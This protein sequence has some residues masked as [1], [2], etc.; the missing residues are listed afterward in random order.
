PGFPV[1]DLSKLKSV[2][3]NSILSN[4]KIY[5]TL[6]HGPS[7]QVLGKLND[8]TKL[9]ATSTIIRPNKTMFEDEIDLEINPLAIEAGFQ[10]AGLHLLITQKQMGLPSGIKQLTIFH[11]NNEPHFIR[12]Q[13]LRSTDS[14]S[15]YDIYILDKEGNVSIKLEEY[16]TIHTGHMEIPGV[17]F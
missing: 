11:Q 9:T 7:Y 5:K 14:F 12:V 10:T 2:F 6:F 17:Q 3:S 1:I 8:V 16:E 4:K 13:Y 15:Y